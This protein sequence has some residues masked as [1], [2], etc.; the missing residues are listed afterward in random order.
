MKRGDT[1]L[2]APQGDQNRH[3]Y[4][5]VTRPTPE[6]GKFVVFNLTESNGGPHALTLKMGE[7]PFIRKDSDVNFGDGLV[8]SISQL[9]GELKR[10]RASPRQ[11][12][13]SPLVEGIARFALAHPAVTLEMKRL[14]R[15]DLEM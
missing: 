2:W 15:A 3:L 9:Q 5:A 13:D 11:P 12:M 10:G 6:H 4:I 7:H 14:I 8:T 1:F